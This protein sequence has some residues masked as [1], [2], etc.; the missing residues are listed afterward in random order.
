MTRMKWA[1]KR[2]IISTYIRMYV[3]TFATCRKCICNAVKNTD[4][5]LP[6]G[7]VFINVS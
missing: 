7:A 6:I 2:H 5:P 1:Y 4:P 3:H